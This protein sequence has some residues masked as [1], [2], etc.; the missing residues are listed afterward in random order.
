MPIIN[1]SGPKLELERKRELAQRLTEVMSDIYQR[2]AAQIIVVIHENP[3][4]NV[5]VGGKLVVDRKND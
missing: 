5:S 4:E 1:V 3:P 2:P